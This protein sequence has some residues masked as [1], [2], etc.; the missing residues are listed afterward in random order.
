M[1]N[2]FAIIDHVM[3]N[4]QSQT[5]T[6]YKTT[7]QPV[8]CIWE[9]QMLRLDCLNFTFFATFCLTLLI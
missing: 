9:Q 7:L 5:E 1:L 4:V 6:Q 2:V 8:F 3:G